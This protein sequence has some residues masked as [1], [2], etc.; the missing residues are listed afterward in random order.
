MF[1]NKESLSEGVILDGQIA[2][3]TLAENLKSGS[4]TTKVGKVGKFLK[5]PHR[6]EDKQLIVSRPRPVALRPR[7]VA[8]RPRPFPFRLTP[9]ALLIPAIPTLLGTA[10]EQ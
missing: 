4:K 10:H 5:Q 7:P 3:K 1:E 6:T 8:L 9:A 2:Y